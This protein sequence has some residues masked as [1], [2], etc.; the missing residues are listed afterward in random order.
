MCEGEAIWNACLGT[1]AL[2]VNVDLPS[3]EVFVP[4]VSH[5]MLM[6]KFFGCNVISRISNMKK[7]NISIISGYKYVIY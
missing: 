3:N 1:T 5:K 2:S 6:L 4:A 7:V